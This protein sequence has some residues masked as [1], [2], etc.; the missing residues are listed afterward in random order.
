MLKMSKVGDAVEIQVG[1]D[2]TQVLDFD[3]TM[4]LFTKLT[5]L[6]AVL[7]VQVTEL[8]AKVA[9]LESKGLN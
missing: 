5:Q 8:K 1:F 4:S 2:K 6:C 7:T 9:K 3:A